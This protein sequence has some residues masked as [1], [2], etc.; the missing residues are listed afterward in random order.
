MGS[1]KAN[2]DIYNKSDLGGNSFVF[3]ASQVASADRGF[4]A[5]TTGSGST[6]QETTPKIIVPSFLISDPL[7]TYQIYTGKVNDADFGS[8]E[9]MGFGMPL[10]PPS[11]YAILNQNL[12]V[13]TC[14]AYHAEKGSEIVVEPF[15]CYGQV[16]GSAKTDNSVSH[17]WFE[18]NP[19][20]TTYD[21]TKK[22]FNITY[23]PALLGDNGSIYHKELTILNNIN[24][25]SNKEL[26]F[27]FLMKKAVGS[28]TSPDQNFDFTMSARYGDEPIKIRG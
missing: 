11:Q 21:T 10:L 19:S 14:L 18:F 1:Y 17:D 6:L 3:F 28:T 7:P 8:G 27:G 23:L 15:L 16:N 4:F 25:I 24:Y 2:Q 12:V 26:I 20:H 5:R 9:C 13:E 22:N